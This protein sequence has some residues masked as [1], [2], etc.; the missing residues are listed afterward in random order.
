VVERKLV[1]G[2]LSC[3]GCGQRLAPWG[4]AAPRFVRVAV[5]DQNI[6]HPAAQERPQV[7]DVRNLGG[8]TNAHSIVVPH[9]SRPPDTAAPRHDSAA[10]TAFGRL[11]IDPR[12]LHK[13]YLGLH[14][15]LF[16][17]DRSTA[18][19]PPLTPM[20]RFAPP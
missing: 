11:A 2:E 12:G 5:S 17:E 20:S 4:H 9:D 15:H 19:T 14:A 1:S 8:T 16:D 7:D 10:A 6:P 18:Q 13:P 3:P